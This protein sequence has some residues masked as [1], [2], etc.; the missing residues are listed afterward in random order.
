M[1]LELGFDTFGDVTVRALSA[2]YQLFFHLGT[3]AA[4]IV[5]QVSLAVGGGAAWRVLQRM[6]AWLAWLM[7]GPAALVQF[8][9]LLL[10]LFGAAASIPPNPAATG[11][12]RGF[13]FRRDRLHRAGGAGLASRSVAGSSMGE[14]RGAARAGDRVLGG[15]RRGGPGRGR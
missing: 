12:R 6:Y 2:L 1:T 4:D 14:A 10:V 15:R 9:M 8:A 7:K 3:L 11:A 5:D 13:R